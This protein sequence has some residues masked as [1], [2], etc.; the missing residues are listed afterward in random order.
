MCYDTVT[1]SNAAEHLEDAEA[2][3]LL[4]EIMAADS[5]DEDSAYR[6]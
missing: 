2:E 3:E 6:P 5:G 4:A 1:E